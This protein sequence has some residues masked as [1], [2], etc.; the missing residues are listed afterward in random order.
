MQQPSD[1]HRLDGLMVAIH[2]TYGV[3]L[4]A[5]SAAYLK[6]RVDRSI[7]EARLQFEEFQDRLPRDPVAF[8][9]FL[10]GLSIHVSELF[11]DPHFYRA[12][13][14]SVIPVLRTYPFLKI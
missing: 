5:Y 1:D 4:R 7:A 3:D 14:E 13:R 10:Q 11:R 12:F 6:R 9:S 2:Q 8:A